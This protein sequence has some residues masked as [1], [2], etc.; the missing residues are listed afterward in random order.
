[1]YP[2]IVLW[3]LRAL[4]AFGRAEEQFE[5]HRVMEAETFVVHYGLGFAESQDV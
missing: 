2:V 5:L 4:R 3:I 1:M